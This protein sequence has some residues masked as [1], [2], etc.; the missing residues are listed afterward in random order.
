ML[1]II[2]SEY[3]LEPNE[4]FLNLNES[5]RIEALNYADAI[6]TGKITFPQFARYGNITGPRDNFMRP[7]GTYRDTNSYVNQAEHLFLFLLS[8]DF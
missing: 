8:T 6:N 7:A 5:E 2:R 1:C 3:V 4:I